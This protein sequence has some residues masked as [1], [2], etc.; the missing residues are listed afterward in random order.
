MGKIASVGMVNCDIPLYKVPDDIKKYEVVRTK[1]QRFIIGGDAVNVAMTTVK[2]GLQTSISGRIGNDPHGH[3]ALEIM[4]NIGINTSYIKVMENDVTSTSCLL[5]YEDGSHS[6]VY[7]SS[8]IDKLS[9][10]D[11]PEDIYNDID[12]LYFGSALTFPL[13]DNG[14][15]AEIFSKA[16]KRG[17]VTVM[18][19]ALV[20][21]ELPESGEEAFNRL[22][23]AFSVTDIFFPSLCEAEFLTGTTCPHDIA[24]KFKDTGIKLL[25]IKLGGRGC[26]VTDFYEEYYF[27]A[28][29]C[30]NIV[31]TVGAGDSFVGGIIYGITKK[32][33]LV[34]MIE[35]A[36]AVAGFNIQK[37]GATEG[38]PKAVEVEN[39]INHNHLSYEKNLF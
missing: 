2:L 24:E 19:A 26:Y 35:F 34:R 16:R 22:K 13:M 30:F 7:F 33:E 18:D 5:I 15:I 21:N 29:D 6:A 31:D 20:G 39:F 12:V 1:P 25:G 11:I 17:I 3:G 27:E 10:G 9:A 38:V 36:S 8:T 23:T 32:W 28:Y 4:K 14:G 37:V